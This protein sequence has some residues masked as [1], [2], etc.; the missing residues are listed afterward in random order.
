MTP[1]TVQKSDQEVNFARLR[2]QLEQERAE[3]LQIK[4]RLDEIERLQVQKVQSPVS[5]DDDDDSQEP[6]VDNKRLK[7]SLT[8]LKEDIKK[9]FKEEVQQEARVLIE[10]QRQQTYVKSNPDFNQTLT[11]E[12]IELFA[13]EHPAIAEGM[14]RMPDTFDR[15]ALLYEQI[16]AFQAKKKEAERASVQQTIDQ[17]RKSPFYHPTGIG[18]A[19]YNAMQGDFSEA[20]QKN[21]YEKLQALKA[22]LRI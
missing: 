13:K 4:Q 12:N 18:T 21:A 10:Q 17:N 16:K 14:L 15:Q 22:R 7:K 5:H 2:K 3:K 20:G 6:Y 19:P 1:E 11:P 9:S 8:N